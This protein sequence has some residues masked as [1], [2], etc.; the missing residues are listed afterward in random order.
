MCKNSID[1]FILLAVTCNSVTHKN[2]L[3]LFHCDIGYAN[4]PKY[5]IACI[6]S[7]FASV[8]LYIGRYCDTPRAVRSKLLF[9]DYLL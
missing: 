5:C 8:P 9:C 4:A 3:L 7:R 1:V 2:V 6:V